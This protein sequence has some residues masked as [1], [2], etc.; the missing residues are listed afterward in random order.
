MSAITLVVSIDV[1]PEH[2]DTFTH[3]VKRHARRTLDFESE[4]H[5]FDVYQPTDGNA[6]IVLVEV[7]EDEAAYQAHA[8]SER[9]YEFSTLVKDMV[10]GQR[11]VKCVGV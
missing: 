10:A 6:D 11:T 3:I 4:C 9:M 2:R 7:Y 5:R 8:I 1:M